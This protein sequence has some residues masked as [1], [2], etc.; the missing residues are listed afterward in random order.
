M[1]M[2]IS[3]QQLVYNLFLY[4]FCEMVRLET[5]N[6]CEMLKAAKINRHTYILSYE[7][8]HSYI[9]LFPFILRKKKLRI[10]IEFFNKIVW[11]N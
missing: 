6:V 9:F 10:I 3:Y 11:N 4:L 8:I 2:R 1:L 5:Y 7:N